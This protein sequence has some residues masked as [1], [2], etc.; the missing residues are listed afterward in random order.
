MPIP[1]CLLKLVDNG[2]LHLARQLADCEL[3]FRV[4]DVARAV[5]TSELS[6]GR[7]ALHLGAKAD[8]VQP[9]TDKNAY[10]APGSREVNF[11]KLQQSLTPHAVASTMTRGS[12]WCP[13]DGT[14]MYDHVHVVLVIGVERTTDVLAP[15][16]PRNLLVNRRMQDGQ[17][18]GS[19][20]S[21]ACGG[22][23]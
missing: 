12:R 2:I 23:D 11:K 15:T 16:Q 19:C 6:L 4:L 8:H 22:Q 5:W 20:S 17:P 3:H 18:R 7:R 14:Q 13:C 10:T 1:C 21:G 9:A